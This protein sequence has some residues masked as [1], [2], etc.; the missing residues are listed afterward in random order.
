MVAHVFSQLPE[1]PNHVASANTAS[2]PACPRLE[3]LFRFG[4]HE[5]L[6]IIGPHRHIDGDSPRGDFLQDELGF[7]LVS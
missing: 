7:A 2:R 3:L 5:R 1:S 4:G 6:L